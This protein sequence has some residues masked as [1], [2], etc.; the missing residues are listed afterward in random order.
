M[1]YVIRRAIKVGEKTYEMQSTDANSMHW[2]NF[3]ARIYNNLALSTNKSVPND[4]NA[5]SDY[6]L[7]VKNGAN[8]LNIYP[9][10]TYA[11]YAGD[12]YETPEAIQERIAELNA[13]IDDT[14]NSQTVRDEAKLNRDEYKKRYTAIINFLADASTKMDFIAPH[15][16]VHPYAIVKFAGM[17]G[18]DPLHLHRH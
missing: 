5:D 11:N 7:H 3:D 12:Y 17:H 10:A 1:S 6:H 9:Y 15:S 13:I 16:L 4:D 18:N 14:N 8:V 2:R